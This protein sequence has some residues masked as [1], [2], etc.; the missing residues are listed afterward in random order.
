MNS[1]ENHNQLNCNIT[2]HQS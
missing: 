1:T 2:I